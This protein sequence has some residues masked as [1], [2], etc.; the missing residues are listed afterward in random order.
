[1][2]NVSLII[3]EQL[4]MYLPLIL[5]GYI[6]FSLLKV[7]NISIESAYVFGS[8]LAANFMFVGQGVPMFLYAP[9]IFLLSFAGGML[10]G[11]VTALLT[12][13]G[14]VPHLLSSILTIGIFHG[15]NQFVLG[16]AHR[17]LSGLRNPLVISE[18][19]VKNPELIM[20]L[21]VCL[22][23]LVGLFLL[24]RT[25][26]GYACAVFGYNPKFFENYGISTNFVVLTGVALANGLAGVSGYLVAQSSGFVDTNAGFGM[27]LF[28]I[29]AL[30]LGKSLCFF[31]RSFSVNV[32]LVGLVVYCALQQLL[33]KVGFNLKYFTMMQSLLV[34]LMVINRFRTS[35]TNK[36]VND[37]GV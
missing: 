23:L 12:Q 8:I 3:L 11:L 1:M 14:R 37:L 5:G 2:F 31:V 34:L 7:P 24:L 32:P 16:N 19:F 27:A 10:V 26:L 4:C 6:A 17:S 20:L 25:Q 33:L 29:T 36:N 30:I 9:I 13:Y 21:V 22:V 18:Y 35:R 15:V 28:C